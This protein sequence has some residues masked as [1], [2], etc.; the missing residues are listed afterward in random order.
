MRARLHSAQRSAICNQQNVASICSKSNQTFL[1]HFISRQIPIISTRCVATATAARLQGPRCNLLPNDRIASSGYSPR[2]KAI[3][4][5]FYTRQ[6]LPTDCH[7]TW[8]SGT[9]RFDF[10]FKF[11][12]E[13]IH[14]ALVLMAAADFVSD[15]AQTTN[16]PTQQT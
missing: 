8:D 1:R 9:I 14:Y 5:L 16:I 6:Y 2:R 4:H 10:Q 13:L 3:Q 12:A 7:L 15:N 11:N